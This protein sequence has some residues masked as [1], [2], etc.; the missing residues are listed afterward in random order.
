M[1][2]EPTADESNGGARMWMT[3]CRVTVRLAGGE[4]KGLV[5]AA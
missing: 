2:Q 5:L 3:A 4:V 1:R